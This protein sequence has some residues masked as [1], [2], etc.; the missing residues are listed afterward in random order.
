MIED[1]ES[2]ASQRLWLAFTTMLL[3][4]GITNTFPVFLPALL[5]E[6]GGSRGA[7]A[8]TASLLWLG[9]ALL[10]PVAGYLVARGNPRLLVSLGLGLVALGMVLGSLAPTL[11]VFLLAMG[12]GGGIG[13]GLTGMTTHAALIAD[14]YVRRRGLATGIA[15]GGSMAAYAL[16]PPAQWI[17]T[18]WGW[19]PAFWCYAAAIVAVIPW[20]WRTHP[21]RLGSVS[22]RGAVGPGEAAVTVA[23]IVRSPG[24]WS[25]LVMFTTP[26]LFG[27]LATTQHILYF[28]ERGFTAGEASMLLAIGGVL[29]GFGRAL[30][31]LVADRF[32]GPTAGFLSFSCSL[33]GMLC[34]IGMEARPLWILAAGY[35]L[36]LF[37]PLGSRAII[38]TV[39]LSR[40]APPAHYGVIFGLLGIGNNLGAALGPW[41]SGVLFDR[42]GSYLV[43]YL[44]AFGAALTGLAALSVFCLTTRGASR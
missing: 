31:G 1:R 16:A 12:L 4:A 42:T 36:F 32:G 25:L 7:T 33:L 40:L 14:A 11:P 5:A 41:L 34:L 28:T 29:A 27:Y 9:G 39:L 24:F 37:L 15:F 13:L 17:I 22:D 30:A 38:V 44:C 26:P 19:R 23:T 35:V 2:L 6:F 43:I 18:H 8:S 10:S 20:A 3:V 21:K